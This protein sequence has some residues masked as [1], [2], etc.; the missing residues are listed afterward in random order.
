MYR[1]RA[2]AL[3]ALALALGLAYGASFGNSFHYDD[4]HSIVDNPGIRTLANLPRFFVD[5]EMFSADAEKRMYRPLL[6]STYA[7]NYAWGEYKVSSYHLVNLSLHALC[8]LLVWGLAAQLHGGV[9]RA[10]FCGLLFAAHPLG[11]EPVNYISSRSEL[12][13]AVFFLASCLA[14]IRFIRFGGGSWYGRALGAAALALLSKSVA[15]VLVFVLPLCDWYF[16]GRAAL[17]QRAA[18]GL[19][20]WRIGR[21][22][23]DT[24]RRV[25]GVLES[26]SAERADCQPYGLQATIR[27]YC[28]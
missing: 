8:S 1:D 16:H 23:G 27:L 15:V 11:S 17:L 25:D 10:F 20:H 4:F 28:Q 9:S 22:S 13:M 7:L 26:L 24:D 5:P 18:R 2:T 6:L 14:Y 19:R 21:D 12:L 3:G